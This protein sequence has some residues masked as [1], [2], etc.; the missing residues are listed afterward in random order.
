MEGS[1]NRLNSLYGNTVEERALAKKIADRAIQQNIDSDELRERMDKLF[2]PEIID[3]AC[4]IVDDFF[5][6]EQRDQ[7]D[8]L[9]D[10]IF[11]WLTD[12]KQGGA[13]YLLMK[14]A[15]VTE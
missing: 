1:K 2:E 9:L 10:D 12:G 11:T 4:M 14:Y 3:M 8:D 5:F 13:S 7:V 6:A 15:K